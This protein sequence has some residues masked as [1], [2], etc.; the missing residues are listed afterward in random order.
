MSVPYFRDATAATL[1]FSFPGR[2]YA[3]S[4]SLPLLGRVLARSLSSNSRQVYAPA[5]YFAPIEKLLVVTCSHGDV[6]REG[7]YDVDKSRIV[8]MLPDG[9]YRAFNRAR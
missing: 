6:Y 4:E 1:R 8:A 5:S 3:T 9:E 2:R 7:L